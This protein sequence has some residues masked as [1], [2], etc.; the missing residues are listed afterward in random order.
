M[1]TAR[2]KVTVQVSVWFEDMEM[3][4][5]DDALHIIK[6]VMVTTGEHCQQEIKQALKD[7][8]ARD[9]SVNMLAY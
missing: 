4:S 8:G 3:E 1:T 6:G 9:V 7:A 2:R 5:T